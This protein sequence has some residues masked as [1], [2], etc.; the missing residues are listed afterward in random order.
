MMGRIITVSVYLPSFKGFPVLM[1]TSVSVTLFFASIF[2][3]LA[4]LIS[5]N[6][7]ITDLAMMSMCLVAFSRGFM[8]FCLFYCLA[9][10]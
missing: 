6:F 3:H 8:C 1:L 2:L 9:G 7:S 5:V 10:E 4:N